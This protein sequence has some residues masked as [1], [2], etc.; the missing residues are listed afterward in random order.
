MVNMNVHFEAL[1]HISNAN[2]YIAKFQQSITNKQI[3]SNS[4]INFVISISDVIIHS[5][6][7]PNEE[8]DAQIFYENSRIYCDMHS[9]IKT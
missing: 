7:G 3:D 4:G 5:L 1:N 6:M 8:K 2:V 9:S